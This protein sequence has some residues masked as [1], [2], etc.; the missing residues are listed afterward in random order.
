[1]SR[2]ADENPL[3]KL[4]ID[5]YY[6]EGKNASIAMLV[7]KGPDPLWFTGE[8]KRE[9]GDISDR[10]IAQD[11]SLA[12]AYQQAARFLEHRAMQAVKAGIP[13]TYTEARSTPKNHDALREPHLTPD[14]ALAALRNK[15]E[16]DL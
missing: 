5:T 6:L 9:P 4:V 14:V 1:M 12:R 3:T 2:H 8:A 11:L 10:Q 7:F 16:A 15:L 13:D